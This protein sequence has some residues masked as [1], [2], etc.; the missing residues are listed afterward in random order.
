M[1]PR[2]RRARSRA[3]T[4]PGRRGRTAAAGTV[5][6]RRRTGAAATAP[7]RPA[8]RTARR[9]PPAEPFSRRSA[10]RCCCRLCR[11][12]TAVGRRRERDEQ[13]P[14]SRRPPPSRRRRR[15]ADAS[16]S[17]RAPAAASRSRPSAIPGH[18]HQRDAH[19]RLEPEPDGT[20]LTTSQRV[21][22]VSSARSGEPNRG[23]GAQHEQLVGVVVARDGDGDRRGRQRQPGDEP[24]DRPKRRREVVDEH[25]R[26][27]PH[28]RLRDEHAERMEAEQPRRQRLYPQR[29]AEACRPSSDRSCQATRTG[30]RASSSPST[31]RRRCSTCSPS[32]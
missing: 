14:R 9:R 8:R 23:H 6:W 13:R 17:A 7:P 12:S 28:Q 10:T 29:R 26:D 25:D 5:R 15:V 22:P 16:R 19:L 1:T 18:D 11:R 31:A 3:A 32:R 24:A 2:P 21:R 30:S 20:P 27:D 4:R